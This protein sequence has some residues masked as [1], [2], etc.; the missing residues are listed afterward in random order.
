MVVIV[1]AHLCR[2]VLGQA[3]ELKLTAAEIGQAE[4]RLAESRRWREQAEALLLPPRAVDLATL[5]AL[6]DLA[7][8]VDDINM[9]L[10]EQAAL[11]E[12]L[13]A[14]KEWQARAQSMLS[15]RGDFYEMARLV[16]EA[17]NL[18]ILLPEVPRLAK[19][20]QVVSL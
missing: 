12:R 3:R 14:V 10:P 5:E 16:K 9:S 17:T 15:G 8:K 4:E 1:H 20:Q 11:D 6:E 13:S 19:Q 7:A 2:A 18:G